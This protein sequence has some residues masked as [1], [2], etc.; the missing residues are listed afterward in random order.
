MALHSFRGAL[1]RTVP[2]ARR[3][4]HLTRRARHLAS[5]G[6]V[7]PHHAPTRRA[8]AGTRPETPTAIDRRQIMHY[9]SGRATRVGQS[10]ERLRGA[11]LGSIV[12]PGDFE[13][14]RG[15]A[16]RNSEPG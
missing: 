11:E 2:P 3:Q 9:Q 10:T 13:L 15:N 14:I 6:N 8:R 1:K 4:W 16:S 12:A 5:C 7:A